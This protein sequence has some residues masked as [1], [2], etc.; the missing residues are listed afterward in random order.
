MTRAIISASACGVLLLA[1]ADVFARSA[2]IV[3][4][5]C[6]NCHSGGKSPTVTLTADPPN[7]AVGM[8]VA[9]TISI[10]QA[11]GASAGFYLT[12]ANPAPGTFQA[13]D[14]GTAAS[15]SGIT[16]SMPRTGSGG[17]TTFHAQ[18]TATQPTGVE[19][20]VYAVSANGDRTNRGDGAGTGRLQLLVGCAGATYYIDQD[21]DGYGSTDPAYPSRLDCSLPA[22]YA[23]L[24][25]D[26]DDFRGEVHPGAIEQCDMKDND[27]NGVVDDHVVNQPYCV[28]SD[29]DG[30]GVVGGMTKMDCKPSAGF[31]D[32]A[33]DCDD[34]D[35]MT[36]PGAKEVCD[37]RDNNCD[38]K[39]DEGVKPLCGVGLCAR[40]A[41]SCSSACTPG[42][43]LAEACDG[44]DEDCDGV[45]DN[46]TNQTLCGDPG[47]SCVQG[48]CTGAASGG[49]GSAPSG[50]GAASSSGAPN[51]GGAASAGGPSAT[52]SGARSPSG[53]SVGHLPVGQGAA[54][55]VV[56]AFLGLWSLTRR[57]SAGLPRRRKPHN[58]DHNGATAATGA[59]GRAR[60][61][62]ECC[63]EPRFVN[64]RC[65]LTPSQGCAA[66]F[67]YGRVLSSATPTAPDMGVSGRCL[68]TAS[69]RRS[70]GCRQRGSTI[71]RR[72][73]ADDGVHTT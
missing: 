59:D 63:L 35:A 37:G 26:C 58:L 46:G 67:K 42:E 70:C 57:R 71:S 45:I 48:H 12:T 50:G 64:T 20:D 30:H 73:L 5:G 17:V 55:S 28:D 9:L 2:G 65:P 14:P 60:R 33:G 21:G 15:T 52:P 41:S 44:F 10:S 53:C 62:R 56:A 39:V 29:G 66:R 6:D 54:F 27:C 18:W 19:F 43:P 22:G 36:Y 23:A 11:N 24:T 72:C 31:G 13:T 16:H 47:I 34:R 68:P 8:P 1:A 38:G 32:C 4:L 7:P 25:G 3:A 51:V 61:L 40:Y 49:A 69:R